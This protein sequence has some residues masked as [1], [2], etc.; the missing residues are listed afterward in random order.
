[1]A[2][3]TAHIFKRILP[4]VS[5][6]DPTPKDVDSIVQN[7]V[8]S[9][10][11]RSLIT[12]VIQTSSQTNASNA[13][14]TQRVE[15]PTHLITNS[16]PSSSTSSP[17]T[18]QSQT[19][20]SSPIAEF[21]AIFRRGAATG[22]QEQHGS[23]TSASFL[24][25]FTSLTARS[26]SRNTSGRRRQ[27]SSSTSKSSSKTTTF[28]REV[29]LFSSPYATSV[30]K[31]KKKAE[32]MRNG[33]VISSFDFNRAW[34]ADEVYQNLRLR[35][36]AKLREIRYICIW[37]HFTIGSPGACC[38]VFIHYRT[39]I[40]NAYVTSIRQAA[41]SWAAYDFT[42]KLHN[43]AFSPHLFSGHATM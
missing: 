16:N 33:Q 38:F 2:P 31:G 32:L 8:N 10:Q 9:P 11:F 18:S 35:F 34:T 21:N 26:R 12:Q 15:T 29:V 37:K 30:V 36:Q 4:R 1:M 42:V 41:C 6:V 28:T 24:P 7:V 40:T 23:G 20:H 14:A 19:Q 3:K 17:S 27:A 13:P 22:R 43:F 5:M 39:I 25:G